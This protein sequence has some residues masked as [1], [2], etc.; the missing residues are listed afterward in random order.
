M[1][2]EAA[3]AIQCKYSS[4]GVQCGTGPVL[5][6][7]LPTSGEPILDLANFIASV[8]ESCWLVAKIKSFN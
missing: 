6:G 7:N 5:L 3:R 1:T 8:D 2:M 4:D